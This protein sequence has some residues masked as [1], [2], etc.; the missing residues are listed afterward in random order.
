MLKFC[1]FLQ[2][3]PGAVAHPLTRLLTSSIPV[4]AAET[5]DANFRS[6]STDPYL[7]MIV[8]TSLPARYPGFPCVGEIAEGLLSWKALGC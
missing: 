2:S 4:P 8:R 7:V 6:C 1:S 5:Q 3:G